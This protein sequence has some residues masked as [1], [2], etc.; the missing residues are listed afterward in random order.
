MNYF[1]ILL[2]S[3]TELLILYEFENYKLLIERINSLRELQK[4]S[5]DDYLSRFEIL[6]VRLKTA[7]K[8]ASLYNIIAIFENLTMKDNPEVKKKINKLKHNAYWLANYTEDQKF[9]F[10]IYHLIEYINSKLKQG[11]NNECTN[12]N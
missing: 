9:L 6:E 2:I 7:S 3:I 10:Y 1:E 12:R 5:E 11:D 8:L 4:I